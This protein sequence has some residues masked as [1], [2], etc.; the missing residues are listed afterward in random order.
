MGVDAC[1]H[2]GIHEMSQDP[3]SSSPPHVSSSSPLSPWSGNTGA[4][5]QPP[6]Q[7]NYREIAY[8]TINMYETH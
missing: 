8:I 2:A 6:A 7:G 4:G 1:S 5:S 3:Q